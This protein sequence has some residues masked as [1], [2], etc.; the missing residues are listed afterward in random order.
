MGQETK[1]FPFST[2]QMADLVRGHDWAATPIGAIATWPGA[3][4]VAVDMALSSEFPT[5][6]FLGPDLLAL[7]NDAYRPLNG[8]KPESLGLPMRDIWSEVWEDIAPIAAKAMA[9]EATFLE[10][11][12][13][14]V[15]R[16]GETEEAYF[17]FCY[18]PVRDETGAVLGIVDTVVETT[19]KVKAERAQRTNA[20]RFRQLFE[21]AP[22]FMALLNGPEHRYLMTNPSYRKLIGGRDV[23]GM[24]LAEALPE[25]VAQG[26][27]DLLDQVFNTGVAYSAL[28][29]T[30]TPHGADGRPEPTR[31]LDFVYQPL[32]DEAGQVTGIF[33]EGA[34]MT[35]RTL[36]ERRLKAMVRLTNAIR[37]LDNIADIAFAAAQV[38]GE[39]LEVS[40]VG[41]GTVDMEDDSF[42][43]ERDWT[44]PGVDSLA[45]VLNLRDFGS[46][47][48]DLK[49]GRF[50]TI[51][52]TAADPRTAQAVEALAARSTRAFVNIPVI[53]RDRTVAVLY[54]N[55][56]EP[57]DWPEA[58]LDFI[59]EVA[60]RVRT[61]IERRRA[62]QDLRD[63]NITLEHQVA[64]RAA[65]VDRI[66]RN[67]RDIQLV[68][69][70]DGVFKS[71]NPAWQTVLG[72]DPADAVG[73]HFSEFIWPDDLPRTQ[74]TL[75]KAETRGDLSDYVNRYAHADGTVRWI[76][77]RAT[78]EGPLIYSYGR[79]ITAERLQA[80]ALDRAEEGL[81]Q[82]QKMEAVGQL[83]GGIAH[84]FNN[85]LAVIMGSLDLLDRRLTPEDGRARRYLSSALEGA[86]RAASLTK[87]LLAFSR[88][89]PLRPE[90]IN[91]NRLVSEMSDL[92]RHSLGAQV[93]LETVLGGGLWN[94]DVDPNQLENVILNLGVNARDAMPDG[95]RL[96][97]E[98]SNAHLDA[99]YVTSRIGVPEGQYVLIA[100]TDTGE[101]MSEEVM[102]RAFDP[103]FTTKEV[104][105]GTGLGLSQVYG[106]V[107]QSGGHVQI[108]SEPGQG[109]TVKIYLPRVLGET[110]EES[111]DLATESLLGESVEV[112]LVVDD[113][114]AVRQLSV[115]ALTELGYR[116]IDAGDAALALKL[117][118]NHPEITLLFTDIVMP[119]TNGRQL[120][121]AARVLRPDLKVLYTT[122]YTRNAVVHNGVLDPGVELITKPYTLDELAAKVRD[123]LEQP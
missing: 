94:I 41:Y 102:A 92:L 111:L 91:A 76:S 34:D 59:R 15:N 18:A 96:T 33:V 56:A 47:V 36:V 106:F 58:D 22:T 27:G 93:R 67:S 43:V 87:R 5:C 2:G 24:T 50:V 13:I 80:E 107:K 78:T 110:A 35:E 97:I 55:A 17:T 81:R 1:S 31:Y 115:E 51:A 101:G 98:T 123:I 48:D 25:A 21:Q 4:K 117:L 75:D 88:Q 16:Y 12:L 122:G 63:L 49:G 38:L 11:R 99:R 114:P 28:G 64:E 86:K 118:E 85:M 69:G 74:E 10:D 19:S 104:G 20:E 54:I 42:T 44:A 120:A 14:E 103:F 68:V 113:E 40:R 7:Y 45:G 109:T 116:V 23:T 121:D 37:D 84:D 71:V 9:G 52:D 8:D 79:D 65:Q 30:F 57:R 32:M 66:W 119:D 90:V 61:A 70:L 73:R 108:Y 46:F 39:T 60:D 29:A 26:Y 62:E 82:A 77:W 112:I 53:E 3:L 95:G 6:L 105:K 72:Y 100:V 83:T 89:Q